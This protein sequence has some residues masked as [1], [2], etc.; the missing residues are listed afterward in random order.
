[1]DV[2]EAR[3]D[4]TADLEDVAEAA[5]HQHSHARRL[6]LDDRVRRDGGGVD[7]GGHVA[8]SGLALREAALQRGHEALR[9]VLGG[10]EHL[11]DADGARLAIDERGVGEHAT[12]V[13]ADPERTHQMRRARSAAVAAASSFSVAASTTTP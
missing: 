12:D 11:D 13:D 5:R 7:H 1:M 8:A 6:A 2:I 9:R 3:A 10:R 4:L